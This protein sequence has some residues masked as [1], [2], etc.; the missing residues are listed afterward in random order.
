M[1][2]LNSPTVPSPLAVWTIFEHA[3]YTFKHACLE[4]TLIYRYVAGNLLDASM[5]QSCTVVCAD[6]HAIERLSSILERA[7]LNTP[8]LVSSRMSAIEDTIMQPGKVTFDDVAGLEK[9]KGTLQ[10]AIVIP[11]LYPHLFTG[12]RR[13]WQRIL[14]YGPP[15]TGNIMKI[16]GGDVYYHVVRS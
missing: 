16:N 15:G 14:L 12:G 11:L 8:P 6:W 3:Q 4:V 2:G 10:E 1:S 9:A 5:V 13:P 7:L